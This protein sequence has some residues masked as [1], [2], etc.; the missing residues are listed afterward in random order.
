MHV[1]VQNVHSS[2]VPMF[3]GCALEKGNK[4][5][6]FPVAFFPNTQPDWTKLNLIRDYRIQEWL[7]FYLSSW[8]ISQ[9]INTVV[10]NCVEIAGAVYNEMFFLIKKKE[11]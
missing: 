8:H 11:T 2:Y 4:A 9:L 5:N 10:R 7:S 3:S 6:P 1:Y